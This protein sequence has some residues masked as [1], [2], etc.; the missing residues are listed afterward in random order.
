MHE[1]QR[2]RLDTFDGEGVFTIEAMV[3][4]GLSQSHSP[5]RKAALHGN[6]FGAETLGNGDRLR[7][8]N[9]TDLLLANRT[10]KIH[11]LEA[12]KRAN[13]FELTIFVNQP[14]FLDVGMKLPQ[15]CHQQTG[16]RCYAAKGGKMD[17]DF[18]HF[19]QLIRPAAGHDVCDAGGGTNTWDKDNAFVFGGRVVIPLHLVGRHVQAI[20]ASLNA[21]FGHSQIVL[22]G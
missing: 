7:V 17:T 20:D 6:A 9:V 2:C 22:E 15:E 12:L 1:F 16:C 3:Q 18:I 4:H 13:R 14:F 11:C 8:R 21:G 10:R 5:W 19:V